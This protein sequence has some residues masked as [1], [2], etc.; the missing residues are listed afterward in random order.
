MRS[1]KQFFK[2]LVHIAIAILC[3]TETKAQD[4]TQPVDKGL[5]ATWELETITISTQDLTRSHSL[6]EL[7]AKKSKLPRNMFTSLYFFENEIGVNSTGAESVSDSNMISLKGTYTAGNGELVVNIY[8]E[9]S[10][11]FNYAIENDILKI[12]YSHAEGQFYLL[13][14][15][16]ARSP[17]V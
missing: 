6:E 8:G 12:S 1:Q 17:D 11:T 13:Y 16:I 3:I 4:N 14:K 15:L 10:R 2:L 5:W 9:Q 7:L